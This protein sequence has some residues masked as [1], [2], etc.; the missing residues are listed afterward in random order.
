MTRSTGLLL[1]SIA[2]S[3]AA[4]ADAE[5][6]GPDGRADADGR[7]TTSASDTSVDSADSPPTFDAAVDDAP[8]A[9]DGPRNDASPPFDG[10]AN[11]SPATVDASTADV[12]LTSDAPTAD[13]PLTFDAP[14]AD[15]PLTFDAPTADV[16]FTF[17]AP[18]ADGGVSDAL[19]PDTC[20]A[21]TKWGDYGPGF[22]FCCA[23]GETLVSYYSCVPVTIS[24]NCMAAS[25]TAGPECGEMNCT[26]CDPFPP[27]DAECGSCPTQ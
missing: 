13:A 11:D 21:Y 6:L 19:E 18:T 7:E 26:T 14:T 16:P 12:P 17:D 8:L 4:C 3:V 1:A 22:A 20:G 15:V 10:P 27:K 2:I 25:T 24:G 23:A 5:T 9:F